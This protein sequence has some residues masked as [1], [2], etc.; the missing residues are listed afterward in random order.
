[1]RVDRAEI[2]ATSVIRASLVRNSANC[3]SSQSL[4]LVGNLDARLDAPIDV[5][6]GQS[7]DERGG[8]ERIRTAVRQIQDAGKAGA[9]GLPRAAGAPDISTHP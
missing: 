7:I 3:V 6:P 4:V 2:L 9:L 5:L 1:M 8:R